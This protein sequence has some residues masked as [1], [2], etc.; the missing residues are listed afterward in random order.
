MKTRALTIVL[1]A[2]TSAALLGA[3]PGVGYYKRVIRGVPLHVIQ[4]DPSRKDVRMAIVTPVLGIGARESWATLVGRA[5]PTAAITGTYFDTRSGI[6][7]GSL[8]F[9]GQVLHRG[10]IGTA[11]R[12]SPEHGFSIKDAKPNTTFDF[13]AAETFLRAGPRL[14]TNGK[15]T[16]YPQAEGFRDPSVYRKNTRTALAI[17][18]H[19]KLLMVATTKPVLLR[20]LASAL[21]SLGAVDAMCLDGGSSTALY[22][23]GKSFAAPKRSLTNVL[24]VYETP[25]RYEKRLAMLNPAFPFPRG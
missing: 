18:K 24:V 9:L 14:L 21:K 1:A 20:T 5:G 10:Y 22:Y 4:V 19:G 12:F 6:P 8:G 25:Q 16:L 15:R 17:T 2:C 13:E 7:I 3:E 23:R 11:F